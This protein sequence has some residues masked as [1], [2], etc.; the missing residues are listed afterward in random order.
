MA[1]IK[2]CW[3]QSNLYIALNSIETNL[4]ITRAIQVTKAETNE[5]KYHWRQRV[6]SCV[7]VKTMFDGDLKGKSRP[8]TPFS[9]YIYM[10]NRHTPKEDEFKC[11]FNCFK[12]IQNL[13]PG[14]NQ[15]STVF[16][17]N[18][19]VS[20]LSWCYE[21]LINSLVYEKFGLVRTDQVIQKIQTH[22]V[23]R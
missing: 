4:D 10:V 1:F 23:L 21:N 12:T 20:V 3:M 8:M 14:M 6:A 2:I 15:F 7:K 17:E 18:L 5:G 11:N 9:I 22:P 13:K 19:V 16:S